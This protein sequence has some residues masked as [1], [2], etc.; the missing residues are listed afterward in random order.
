MKD[1]ARTPARLCCQRL[2]RCLFL[3]SFTCRTAQRSATIKHKHHAGHVVVTNLRKKSLYGMGELRMLTYCKTS[4][5]RE[6]PANSK[7]LEASDVTYNS[8]V[9]CCF[10]PQLDAACSSQTLYIYSAII[11]KCWQHE[12]AVFKRSGSLCEVCPHASHI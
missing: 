8:M 7:G 3:R 5:N 12:N 1:S 10:P 2:G 9:A 11:E 4:G 6:V